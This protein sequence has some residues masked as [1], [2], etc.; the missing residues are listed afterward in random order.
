MIEF[1]S[2]ISS[3]LKT[4]GFDWPELK[5]LCLKNGFNPALNAAVIFDAATELGK[6]PDMDLI[7][8]KLK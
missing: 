7:V 6:T 8:K 1:N 2:R 3:L 5:K 4:K